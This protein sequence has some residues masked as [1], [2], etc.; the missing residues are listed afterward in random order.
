MNRQPLDRETE[1]PQS[2][3]S[4][5]QEMRDNESEQESAQE[6]AQPH[7]ETTN[8]ANTG[9]AAQATGAVPPPGD[10]LDARRQEARVL[11]RQNARLLGTEARGQPSTKHPKPYA[12][13]AQAYSQQARNF[14]GD[15]RNRQLPRNRG[16]S[17]THFSDRKGQ[18]LRRA[19]QH[20]HGR[21]RH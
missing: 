21:E 18:E 9:A 17:H 3:T 14:K 4:E 7:D 1:I 20:Q 10:A 12:T 16:T 19:T 13:Q 2:E 6:H 11:A 5:Q 15:N 8:Q